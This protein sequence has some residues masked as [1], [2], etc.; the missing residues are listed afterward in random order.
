MK[1]KHAI[2]I[3]VFGYCLD[4]IGTLQKVLHSSYANTLLVIGT[5]LKVAGALLFLYK[6]ITYPGFKNFWNR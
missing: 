4:Y 2:I 1:A 6:L 5:V 3:F